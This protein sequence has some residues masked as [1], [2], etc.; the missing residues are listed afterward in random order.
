MNGAEVHA[1]SRYNRDPVAGIRWWQAELGDEPTVQRLV[2]SIK[3]D[4]IFHLAS[5]VEGTRDR[6]LVMPTF[7]SNLASTVNILNAA[8]EL[9]SCRIILCGSLEEPSGDGSEAV[10]CSPY[11]IAKWASSAY[12]RM[13]HALYGAR[14][15]MLRLFMVY[16]PEQKDLRKL[17]PYVVTSALRGEVPKLSSGTRPIDWIYVD[18]VVDGLLAAA[19]APNVEGRTLDIGSGQLTTIR[20]VVDQIVNITRSNLEPVFGALND[21]PLEQVRSA[22]TSETA[23]LT[24][25]KP[26]TSLA[27]G[28][29]RTISWYKSMMAGQNRAYFGMVATVLNGWLGAIPA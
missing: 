28:L 4:V 10:A 21:R 24:G 23:A 16:G 15:T 17:I 9:G 18:D 29:Q 7:Q 26:M 27:E 25:W 14:V 22:N 12:A 2:R 5:H 20:S 1:V 3:P 11:A 6:S 8:G 13:F 19:S